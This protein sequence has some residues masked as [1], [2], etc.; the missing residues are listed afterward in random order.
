MAAER[1]R[2]A[3]LLAGTPGETAA[4]RGQMGAYLVRLTKREE[5]AEGTMAF[6]LEKPREF[7]ETPFQRKSSARWWTD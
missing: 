6:H 4:R 7:S 2:V 1:R 3:K 5:I